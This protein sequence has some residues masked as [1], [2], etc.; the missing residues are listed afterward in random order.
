M[1][2]ALFK[3]TAI[4]VSICILVETVPTVHVIDKVTSI[5]ISI[6]LGQHPRVHRIRPELTLKDIPIAK[7]ECSFTFD[8]ASDPLTLVAVTRGC[9]LKLSLPVVHIRQELTFVAS[10]FYFIDFNTVAL[11]NV[12][13]KVH[14]SIRCSILVTNFCF[15]LYLD[16][17][18]S[19]SSACI[20]D[21][22]IFNVNFYQSGLFY[23]VTV[24]H[25]SRL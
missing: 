16:M 9:V 15:R 22:L 12:I 10:A 18:P 5:L 23:G 11:L 25:V 21:S 1:S 3:V 4:G 19:Y 8:L 13:C 17:I 24:Y 2:F 6:G 14:A 20:L 7:L